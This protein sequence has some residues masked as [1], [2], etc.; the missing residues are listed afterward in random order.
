ML[1]NIADFG[2]FEIHDVPTE[3][4]EGMSDTSITLL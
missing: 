3:N 1:L 4:K 2:V